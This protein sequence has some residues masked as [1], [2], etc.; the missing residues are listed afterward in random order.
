MQ[1]EKSFTGSLFGFGGGV[2]REKS[3]SLTREKSFSASG[4]SR[5]KSF[6]L[7][8]SALGRRA[9]APPI[10]ETP[11]TITVLV[12]ELTQKLK[13][14]DA[15]CR[16]ADTTDDVEKFRVEALVV[17]VGE[18]M[19]RVKNVIFPPDLEAKVGTSGEDAA[20]AAAICTLTEH[21]VTQNT[22]PLL[23]LQLVNLEFETRKLV[24]TL[25]VYLLRNDARFSSTYLEQHQQIL[26]QL[27]DCYNYSDAALPAG[28]M[29]RECIKV[30]SM[31]KAF[32][33]G[34]DGA[35]S[36]CFKN[37]LE[38]HVHNLNFD[39]ASDAFE[40]LQ[41]VLTTNKSLV[42]SLFDPEKDESSRAR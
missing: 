22:V 11:A 39:V 37:L 16:A 17:A 9:A 23:L 36:H 42:L 30:E 5:E 1:R 21:I 8:G 41:S 34:P 25:F 3:F 33:V 6:S 27:V 28:I 31:H 40:T 19:L 14:M 18:L 2:Q 10:K 29:L 24:S 7:G 38:I 35:L 26:G 20:A 15:N 13:D 32:F 12:S 4:L